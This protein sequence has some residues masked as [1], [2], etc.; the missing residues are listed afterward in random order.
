VAFAEAAGFMPPEELEEAKKYMAA[1]KRGVKPLPCRGKAECES[2]CEEPGNFK[3]CIEFAE[4]AGFISPEEA[5]MARKTGGKGPGNCRGKEQC[6]RYCEDDN[7]FAV[8]VEFALE[9]DLMSP[10]EAEMVRKTGGKGPGN[11]KGREECDNFCNNPANQKTCFNFAKEHDLLNPEDLERMEEGKE[12]IL[13]SYEGAPEEV[14]D[15]I[16][17]KL[18]SSFIEDIKSGAAMPDESMG[19]VMK[20]CFTSTIQ[21]QMQDRGG[22]PGGP[23]GG[24]GDFDREDFDVPEEY[25]DYLDEELDRGI[26]SG[27]VDT[28]P[29]VACTDPSH[30]GYNRSD[31]QLYRTQN[32]GG[33]GSGIQQTPTGPVDTSPNVACTDPSHPGYNRPDCQQYRQ[34]FPRNN[35]DRFLNGMVGLFFLR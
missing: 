1:L 24:F 35:L 6:E 8:C 3:S 23:G 19:S 32:Q 28:S 13:D 5:E 18:G 33:Q 2:Y 15:C 4:A 10:E 20:E 27:S 22:G 29:N 9:H 12:R 11:C 21:Q 16:N 30:P 26:E 31:C 34:L 25:Q 7:N 14:Q 17:Q